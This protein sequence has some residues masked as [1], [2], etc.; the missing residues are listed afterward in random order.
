[1]REV[2]RRRDRLPR[3]YFYVRQQVIEAIER[4][5]VRP[6]AG[7][8]ERSVWSYLWPMVGP[9][10]LVGLGSIMFWLGWMTR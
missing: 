10:L 5:V 7:R 6:P 2:E 8:R 4:P 9:M 3:T 1:M